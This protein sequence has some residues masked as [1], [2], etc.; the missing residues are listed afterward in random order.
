MADCALASRL[1]VTAQ[2]DRIGIHMTQ[3]GATAGLEFS[4]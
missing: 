2:T 3:K 1:I 4:F